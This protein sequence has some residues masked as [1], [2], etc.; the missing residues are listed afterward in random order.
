MDRAKPQHRNCLLHLPHLL[1]VLQGA[2]GTRRQGCVCGCLPPGHFRGLSFPRNISAVLVKLL[3]A[4]HGEQWEVGSDGVTVLFL[5]PSVVISWQH[6]DSPSTSV[7][8][9]NPR[10]RDVYGGSLGAFA[11]PN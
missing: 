3:E 2:P 10:E 6:R 4:P 11:S 9:F 1:P 5:G 7:L 8:C